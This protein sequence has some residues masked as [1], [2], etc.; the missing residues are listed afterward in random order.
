MCIR[1]SYVFDI[2]D[3]GTRE[4]S[5]TPWLWQLEERHMDSVTAMLERTYEVSGDDLAQQLADVAAKLADEYW[6]EHQ[7]DFRYIVDGS[8]L[9]EYDLSLIHI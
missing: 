6:N 7:Q 1:D 2:A 4:H 5:R 8:F 3:T 9:E